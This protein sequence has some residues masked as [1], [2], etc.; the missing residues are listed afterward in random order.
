MLRFRIRRN[1]AAKLQE[2]QEVATQSLEAQWALEDRIAHLE[3]ENRRSAVNHVVVGL[4]AIT[5]FHLAR[6]AWQ[7]LRS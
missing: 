6:K 4:I 7:E 3:R 5:A 2:L 1:R